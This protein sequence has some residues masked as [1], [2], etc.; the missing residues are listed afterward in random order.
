MT[1][2][3]A[4]T[5]VAALWCPSQDGLGLRR[6]GQVLQSNWDLG[7]CDIWAACQCYGSLAQ[8]LWSE[9][10]DKVHAKA[11]EPGHSKLPQQGRAQGAL[12]LFM[13]L[14][15]F[16]ADLSCLLDGGQL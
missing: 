5:G 10:G 8:T 16:R 1:G 4:D 13:L 14:W 9:K 2:L 15:A 6:Q 3:A 7:S 12:H 11:A